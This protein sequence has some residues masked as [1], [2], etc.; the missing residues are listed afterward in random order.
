[1]NIYRIYYHLYLTN[2]SNY[3]TILIITYFGAFV[4][5]IFPGQRIFIN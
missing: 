3:C 5:N 1:M 2:D 4:D